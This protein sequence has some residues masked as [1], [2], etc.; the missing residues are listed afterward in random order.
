MERSSAE[1]QPRFGSEPP[2]CTD[3]WSLGVQEHCTPR[4]WLSSL[5]QAPAIGPDGNGAPG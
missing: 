1:Q 2:C 4:P 3:G 5:P